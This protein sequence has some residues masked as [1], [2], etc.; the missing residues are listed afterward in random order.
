HLKLLKN[1]GLIYQAFF[2]KTRPFLNGLLS[3][4]HR[5][6]GSNFLSEVVQ[7]LEDFKAFIAGMGEAFLP[8]P[9]L[10]Y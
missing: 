1:Q 5:L 4:S 10:A 8:A 2:E 6:A 7:A 3:V 9:A